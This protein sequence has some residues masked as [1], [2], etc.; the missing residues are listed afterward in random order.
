[1]APP[2]A[3]N[4]VPRN[5]SLFAPHPATFSVTSFFEW[6]FPCVS[7]P[8][9]PKK[10]PRKGSRSMHLERS[11]L[12]AR[13]TFSVTRAKEEL[14]TAIGHTRELLRRG[15][16]TVCL[17]KRGMEDIFR[18]RGESK[19]SPKQPFRGRRVFQEIGRRSHSVLREPFSPRE[20]HISVIAP[21]RCFCPHRFIGALLT[22]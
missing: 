13:R 18:V 6:C 12:G 10:H 1:M 22:R 5:R 4:H 11:L 20:K 15:S 17:S 7:T 21:W 14:F 19:L 8:L 16:P 9:F 3:A 2:K